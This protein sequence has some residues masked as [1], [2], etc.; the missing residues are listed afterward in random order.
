MT[1]KK[2][3]STLLLLIL[4]IGVCLTLL[5]GTVAADD[6]VG[7]LPLTTV[8]TGTVTGGL[9][10]SGNPPSA[11]YT[12]VVDRTFTLPT[13]AVAGSGRVKWARL[14][15][16][17]YCGHM[18][19][20]KAITYTTKVDWNND[21]TWDNSWTETDPGQPFIYMQGGDYGG[22]GNDNSKFSGH[23]TGEPYLMLNDHTTR[24]TSDY[25]S[26]YDVT[27]LIQE[28]EPTIKVNV[29][30]TGSYDGRI[31]MIELVVAYDDPSS[32]TET[33]Y[34]VNEGHDACTYYTEEN[35]DNVAVGTTTFDTSGLSGITS[36]TLIADY[37]A[38]NNGYYGFP[39]ADNDFVASTKTGSFTNTGLDNDADTQGPYSG[40]DSWNVT[41]SISGSSSTFAYA[42]YLPG[43]GT[44]SI[45][46]NPPR[47]PGGEKTASINLCT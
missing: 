7:G 21:G 20:A 17:S 24:V 27:N 39:T 37:M 40:I 4:S 45:L 15:V 25:L 14:Y 34:W 36:A 9:Y 44:C 42:R 43:T 11:T 30:A 35:E 13:A 19:D 28:N 22:G 33:R 8:Q 12:K 47:V 6:W 18:Q 46:Q 23:G 32:T 2:P 31:K 26:W 5:A 38:S 3:I 29:D 1:N 16:S 41:S 10:I